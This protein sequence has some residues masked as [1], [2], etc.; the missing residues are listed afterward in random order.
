MR[1]A[2]DMKK[3]LVTGGAGMIGSNLS[4]RLHRMGHNVSVVD[5][6]WRGSKDNLLAFFEPDFVE[7]NFSLADLS[8]PGTC[9]KVTKGFDV[10][11]HLADIVGGISYVFGN[12]YSVYQKNISINTNTLKASIENDVEHFIYV[13]T[14]CS[15]P[16][17]LTARNAKE[18]RLVESDAYPAQPESAYGWS[19]LMGEYELELAQEE[20]FIEGTILRLHN[21]YGFPTEFIGKRSQVIPALARKILLHPEEEFVVWGSG[22][23]RRSFVFVDDVVDALVLAL[24]NGINEGPIQIG[25]AESTSIREIAE[26]LTVI[27]GKDVLPRFDSSKPEGD[28]DRVGDFSRAREI[29]GWQQKTSLR[30]GLALTFDWIRSEINL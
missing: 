7:H 30:D 24:K 13:G 20:N 2:E 21:V 22:D 25:P 11:F 14:A 5:N 18:V 28:G 8:D 4:A 27:S 15:Y 29:L 12:Q 23:Q 9:K 6:L 16:E 26:A 3:I 19:K 17:H 10:V 1:S